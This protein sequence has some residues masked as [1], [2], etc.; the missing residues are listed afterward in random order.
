[1]LA[2]PIHIGI[3]RSQFSAKDSV[4]IDTSIRHQL[5]Q[6]SIGLRLRAALTP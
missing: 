6:N 2:I 4:Q 5:P 3:A 1:M